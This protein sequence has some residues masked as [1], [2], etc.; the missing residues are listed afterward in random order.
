M[1]NKN[2]KIGEKTISLFEILILV[3]SVITF[4]YFIGNEF[5]FASASD[6]VSSTQNGQQIKLQ[7]VVE[8]D[9]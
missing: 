1:I 3:V 8:P 7:K 5:G 6:K 9:G 2:K 4:S